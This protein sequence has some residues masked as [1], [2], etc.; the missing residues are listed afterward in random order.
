M[1]I[2][3]AATYPNT[4]SLSQVRE[5]LGDIDPLEPLSDIPDSPVPAP[6]SQLRKRGR[7]NIPPPTRKSTR[8]RI[9]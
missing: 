4:M 5:R 8:T 9:A 2:Q 6:K 1:A 3:A 7:E